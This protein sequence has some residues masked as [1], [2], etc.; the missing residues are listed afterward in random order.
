MTLLSVVVI[1]VSTILT[2]LVNDYLP[3]GG[4]FN[5]DGFH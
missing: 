5:E 1:L 3:V 4:E 2:T